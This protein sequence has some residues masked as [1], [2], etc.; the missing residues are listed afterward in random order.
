MKGQPPGPLALGMSS[1]F[2]LKMGKGDIWK[3]RGLHEI[4]CMEWSLLND[5]DALHGLDC[6]LHIYGVF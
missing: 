2:W 1:S 6:H 4:S 5:M 3:S